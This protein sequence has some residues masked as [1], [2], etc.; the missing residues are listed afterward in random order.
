MLTDPSSQGLGAVLRTT[1]RLFG[2][3]NHHCIDVEVLRSLAPEALAERHLSP[4]DVARMNDAYRCD[5]PLGV[6]F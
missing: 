5:R 6:S 2:I 3:T 1:Q 4:R